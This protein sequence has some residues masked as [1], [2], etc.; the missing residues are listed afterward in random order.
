VLDVVIRG[1]LVIDGSGAPGQRIDVGIAGDQ[2][3]AL[4]DLAQV[5]A[6]RV[7]DATGRIVAPGFVDPHSHSDWTLHANRSADSTIRQGVTTEV[8]GNCGVGMA[9][10]SQRSRAAVASR[11]RSH[12]YD[13][14]PTWR[15]F[16]EYLDE[17]ASQ[18]TSQNLAFFVGH[19]TIRDATGVGLGAPTE[20]DIASMRGY[21]EEAMDAGALGLSTGLEY[22]AGRYAGTPELVELADVVGR[23]GG[24]YASHIRN[25]DQHLLGAVD[26][27][28]HIVR[29]AGCSGQ[30]SHLNVRH[31][32]GAPPG[33]WSDAVEM[34]LRARAD[35]LDIE[36]DTTPF[37]QGLGL[38][39]ALLPE[40]L[41][42]QG[43]EEAAR[44]LGDSGVRER[45]RADC[46]RYWR[47]VHKGQWGRVRLQSSPQFPQWSGLRFT[48]IAE[49]TG[50]DE[51]DCFFDI[52]AAG[53]PA[54]A[55]LTM[56]GELFTDE[57]LAEMIAH[58]LFSLGV[59][60]TTSSTSEPLASITR[61]PLP[62][63]GHIEY[64]AHHVRA[65]H[66]LT[67]EEAVHKMAGKPAA[68]FGLERRGLL[69]EGYYADV[70]IFDP[71]T[72]DSTSTFEEP[73][74]Y[75]VGIDAVLVNGRVTV[76]RG[77]HTGARE[78]RVLRRS[79]ATS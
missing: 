25:R 16:G 74:A 10:V 75:P 12:A 45:V 67:L 55:D 20:G 77:T 48:D 37:R 28:L 40:W 1:G 41:L 5:R 52:L 38:M 3:A 78:G 72:V 21:V 47:F 32:T 35:G 57:H 31:D 14:P 66:T 62:Y 24:C 49:R 68:R 30:V 53:G 13:E 18:G 64:L 42:A 70:V 69:R 51:W 44:Q 65:E 19:S 50:R 22:G 15:S 9:P 33:G 76:E 6:G 36:A 7:I 59:D 46:D 71:A 43:L 4:G 29:S 2:L 23:H 27:F 60:A 39:I 73:A 56:V 54:M 34:I 11:L 63:R 58:P 26:E 8:V 79:T 61:S 17:V